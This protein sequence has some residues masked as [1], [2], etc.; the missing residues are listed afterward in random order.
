MVLQ[1]LEGKGAVGRQ[2]YFAC[3]GA[4]GTLAQGCAIEGEQPS[5]EAA[6]EA[7]VEEIAES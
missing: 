5:E 4:G 6:E 3:S 1:L 2:G 7:G